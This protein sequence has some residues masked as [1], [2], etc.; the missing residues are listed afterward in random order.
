MNVLH[1]DIPRTARSFTSRAAPGKWTRHRCRIRDPARLPAAARAKAAAAGI[2]ANFGKDFKFIV[3]NGCLHGMSDD[4]RDH[5]VHEVTAVGPP[6][7]G[8]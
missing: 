4:D 2:S 1:A 5:Y 3:D 6:T 7:R 8:C